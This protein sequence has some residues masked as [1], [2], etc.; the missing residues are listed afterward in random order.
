MVTKKTL[1]KERRSRGGTIRRVSTG[2]W[3]V[4]LFRLE[5]LR[6][7][8]FAPKRMLTSVS[9]CYQSPSSV[10]F[11][12][13]RTKCSFFNFLELGTPVLPGSL[14]SGKLHPSVPRPKDRFC[15]A[16]LLLLDSEREGLRGR[17]R[18]G[19]GGKKSKVDKV[20]S[21]EKE[22]WTGRVAAANT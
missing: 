11:H 6:T 20:L 3:I 2:L 22:K 7:G 18:D 12:Y 17:G 19:K 4:P 15:S 1:G 16:S 10:R 21:G 5:R 9:S 8:A 14:L 13:T